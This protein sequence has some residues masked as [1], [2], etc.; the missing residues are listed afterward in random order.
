MTKKPDDMSWTR[1]QLN[2]LGV[3][4]DDLQIVE[5]PYKGAGSGED[6]EH[7]CWVILVYWPGSGPDIRNIEV[8]VRLGRHFSSDLRVGVIPYGSLG[9]VPW[10]KS[11]T[12]SKEGDI[13]V[14]PTWVLMRDGV[15]ERTV[16]LSFAGG[17]LGDARLNKL[18]TTWLT[19]KPLCPLR[20]P[21]WVM[22]VLRFR[23]T[24]WGTRVG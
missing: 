5:L 12:W 9:D 15:V 14:G 17:S 10:L 11:D 21:K 20:P 18:V 24:W 4:P 16:K 7:G 13:Y 6:A 2:R 3:A 1:F 23:M 8:A 19:G 22:A